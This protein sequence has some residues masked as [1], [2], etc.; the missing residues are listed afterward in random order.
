MQILDGSGWRGTVKRTSTVHAFD[1]VFLAS[2]VCN[3]VLHF[4]SRCMQPVSDAPF[5]CNTRSESEC[6]EAAS[7]R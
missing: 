2:G 6:A 7:G 4:G 5:L 1:W 3:D